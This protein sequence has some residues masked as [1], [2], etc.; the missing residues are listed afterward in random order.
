MYTIYTE[1]H[2]R[3]ATDAVTLN[4]E[5]LL[6]KEVPARAEVVLAAIRAADLGPVIPPTDHGFPPLLAVHTV[7]YVEFLWT[8]TMRHEAYYGEPGPVMAGRDAVTNKRAAQRP[9][10]TDFPALRDYYTYDYEETILA[11][12][13]DA[14]YWAAQCALT[15]ADCVLQGQLA[16]YALCRPPG[17]HA[18]AD[19]Y[20]GFCYLNNAAIAARYLGTQTKKPVA[21]LD[22]DYHHGN[23]TQ[24]IF[25]A[26]P[27]VLYCSL[28]AD[29]ALEYPHFWGYA[30]ERGAGAGLGTNYNFPL[31]L[32]VDDAGYL[33]VLDE[34]LSVIRAFKP[35]SLVVSLGLDTAEGDLIGDFCLTPAGFH[36]IGQ[37]IAALHLPTVL[38]QE[39]GYN[40]D[41]LGQNAVAVL[42]AI[43][44]ET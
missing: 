29:P 26:D 27:S 21:I 12:T 23:G 13:W 19:Q 6:C 36:A 20:G 40:L 30:A 9:P 42:T 38:V 25:Y 22:V 7:D 10:E 41:T 3:H 43:K 5:P 44:Q 35:G 39:G 4:G 1:H 11:G 18:S 24:S 15:A 17:H 37:R 34:A 28:H 8:A 2:Q 14:A 31:P 33:A 32:Y 16:A